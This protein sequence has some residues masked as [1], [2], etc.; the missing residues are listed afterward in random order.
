MIAFGLISACSPLWGTRDMLSTQQILVKSPTI[1]SESLQASPTTTKFPSSTPSKM[2]TISFTP[3]REPTNSLTTEIGTYPSDTPSI[4]YYTQP[5]D[6][7]STIAK[8][9]G[10]DASEITSDT[11]LPSIGLIAPQTLIFLPDGINGETSDST[12]L[13][14][15]SEI[16]FSPSAI[17]FNVRDFVK[18]GGGYLNYYEEYLAS[19]GMT[20]GIDIIIRIAIENSINPRLLLAI[21]EY[22]NGWVTGN[23][24]NESDL[25]FTMGYIDY[26]NMGLY[27]QLVL[28]SE[29]ISLGYYGWRSGSLTELV[30]LDGKS[31]RISPSLNAGTVGLYYYFSIHNSYADWLSIIDP[32]TGFMS[33]YESMMGDPWMRSKIIEPIFPYGIT[34]PTLSLPFIPG[35]G[36]SLTGGPHSAFARHG[37]WAALDFGPGTEHSTPC[38]QSDSWILAAASG[39][40]VRSGNGIVILDLD[41]DGYEQT[42]WN[43]LYLH[44]A[45]KDRVQVG[46]LLNHDDKIGHPSCEGGSSTGVHF[47]MARKFNGE[48]ILADGALPFNLSGWIAKNGS[49]PYKGFLIRDDVTV[50]ASSTGI[51]SSQ[52][53]RLP[54]E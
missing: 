11:Q 33:F 31:L 9:F 1:I 35:D 36:W 54:G 48:W 43:I 19:S 42:G 6:N 52:I 29:D 12:Q 50:I 18:E 46:E 51:P 37:A 7:L 38:Y 39:Q 30:F 34:Q 4:S 20:S 3:S 21:L 8:H 44:V 5:G 27:G 13:I 26:F 16:I 2:P 32:S 15:D 28:A 24:E 10:V 40:V 45:T 47:H 53:V 23:L 14:P 17:D 22:Q 49:E 41:N 25:H